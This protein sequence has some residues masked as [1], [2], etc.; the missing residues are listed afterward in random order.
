M[1]QWQRVNVDGVSRWHSNL[2]A[3]NST[4]SRTIEWLLSEIQKRDSE[5]EIGDG[6]Q[7]SDGVLYDV[8]VMLGN[9]SNLLAMVA[10]IRR[11]LCEAGWEPDGDSYKRTVDV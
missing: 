7:D 1:K 2:V 6:R 10:T 9:S 11:L 4:D 8:E 3:I 5:C